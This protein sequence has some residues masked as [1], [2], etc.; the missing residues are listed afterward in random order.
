MAEVLDD[1]I[2]A[3]LCP[4][5]ADCTFT[6]TLTSRIGG[7]LRDLET[8]FG[9]RDA[10][11][12]LLGFEF[13]GERPQVWFPGDCQ[14]VVIQLS[15]SAMSDLVEA[16]YQASHE[17]VHLLDPVIAGTESVLEEGVAASFA[18][19]Q[20]RRLNA[21]FSSGA[22]K[23]SFAAALADEVT[24]KHPEAIVKIRD[25]GIRFSSITPDQLQASCP[26]LEKR[27]A[28]ILCSGFGAW[29]GCT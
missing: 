23:Y 19:E 28:D 20:A 9:P 18:L 3:R 7:I 4:P 14:H 15:E 17:C 26:G 6:W 10:S 11:F 8:R 12:T 29:D 27:T 16:V 22:S 25:H 24:S 2:V 5:G 1:L 13:C 21:A